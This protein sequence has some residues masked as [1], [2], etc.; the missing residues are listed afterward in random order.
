VATQNWLDQVRFSAEGLVTVVA[1]AARTGEVLMVAW[2]TREALERTAQTGQAHY[3]SRS[4]KV[5]W[6]KGESSGHRQAVSEIRLDCDGDTVLYR[7]DQTGPACHEGTPTCFSRVVTPD[8]SLAARPDNIAH[9]LTRLAVTVAQRA[10]DRP[11][12]SYTAR[13]LAEGLPRVSQKVGEEALEVVIAAH[14]EAGP[15]LASEAA[16]LLFHLLVLLQARGV[17]LDAVWEELDGRGK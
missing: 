10:G 12:G 6:L 14:T 2:A 5:L 4:R 3:W 15:R 9:T 17:P 1:Q 8:G 13:L 16:D 7:V 11:E